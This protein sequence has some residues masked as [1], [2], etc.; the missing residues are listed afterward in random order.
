MQTDEP[1]PFSESETVKRLE[2]ILV[3]LLTPEFRGHNTK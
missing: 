1:E 3:Q 2:A